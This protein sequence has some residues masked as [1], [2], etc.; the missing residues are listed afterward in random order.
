MCAVFLINY[1]GHDSI[2]ATVLGAR[3]NS[4]ILKDRS[5]CLS[6]RLSVTLVSHAYAFKVSKEISHYKLTTEG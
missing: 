1:Y 6:V 5:V 2:Q 4:A 3:C